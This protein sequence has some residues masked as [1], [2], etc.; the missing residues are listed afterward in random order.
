MTRTGPAILVAVLK[1]VSKS[2]HVLLNGIEAVMKLTLHDNSE[3]ASPD[4]ALLRWTPSMAELSEVEGAEA[5]I[6]DRLPK[7]L[8]EGLNG[9]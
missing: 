9:P 1:G 5:Q 8:P 6:K 3:I 2:V 7:K 4:V